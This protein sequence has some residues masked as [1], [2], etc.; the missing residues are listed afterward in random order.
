MNKG[1]YQ[2]IKILAFYQ[3]IGGLIGIGSLCYALATQTMIGGLFLVLFIAFVLYTYSIW[4][5]WTLLKNSSKGLIL[6][7]VNQISQVIVFI[8]GAYGYKYIS[9]IS[10]LIVLNLTNGF[11]LF[12]NFGLSSF[13]FNFNLQT[14]SKVVGVNVI[15]FYLVY[16]IN[17]VRDK[18]KE[19]ELLTGNIE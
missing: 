7:L 17:Q 9:G 5:G 19:Q 10:L 18:M 1:L 15:A 13:H 14:N 12:L 11:N 6:S 4:C 16:F 2:K 3:I 8:L